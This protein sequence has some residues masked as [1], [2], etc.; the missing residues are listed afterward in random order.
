MTLLDLARTL[1]A[2]KQ[3]SLKP[4]SQRSDVPT[5]RTSTTG[6][7]IGVVAADHY[8]TRQ[9][10]RSRRTKQAFLLFVVAPTLAAAVYFAAFASNRYVSQ[11]QL[12]VLGDSM[13]VGASNP[14]LSLIAP[15]SVSPS[16]TIMLYNYLQSQEMVENLDKTI[17]LRQ[18]FAAPDADYLSRMRSDA[19][20]EDFYEYYL[21]R[22][23][24]TVEPNSPVLTVTA[25]AFTPKDA[26]AISQG[27]LA[28]SEQTLNKL[29]SKRQNDTIAFARAEVATAES[30]L[31]DVQKRIT[32]YR[33]Q[34]SE[35]DPVQA[36][37]A[38]GSVVGDLTKS[39]MIARAKLTA[40]QTYLKAKNSQ[41]QLQ[42]AE[43]E[44]I[45]GQ[46]AAARKSLAGTTDGT[47]AALVSE[48]ETLKSEEELAQ[49][50]YSKSLEFLAVARGDAQRQHAYVMGLV[51]PT[52][53]EKSTEPRRFR[54]VLTV[55]VVSLLCFGIALLAVTAIR[56]HG[57]AA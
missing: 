52:L 3:K 44:S 42:K 37:S 51:S 20:I 33:M 57:G 22:V 39:L 16:G 45:E 13:D 30:R 4:S 53:P 38:V 11:V 2:S 19:E 26:Q 48:Y 28:I 14:L 10:R 24:V 41:V 8:R 9:R 31:V 56:E 54:S 25:E 23:T 17:G 49:E 40:M 29:L 50:G 47:Y 12:V 7:S 5:L 1:I 6:S 36:A 32:E 46:L 34:H 15:G 55:F 27:L 43:V 18:R 21:K 35:I